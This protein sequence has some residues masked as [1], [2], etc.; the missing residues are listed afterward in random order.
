MSTE[1]GF[2]CDWY[3]DSR[4]LMFE[5]LEQTRAGNPMPLTECDVMWSGT[6]HHNNTRIITCALIQLLCKGNAAQSFCSI[7]Q[8][9]T[10]RRAAVT[11]CV[12]FPHRKLHGTFGPKLYELYMAE[13][14]C[15]TAFTAQTCQRTGF[16]R[17]AHANPIQ[18]QPYARATQ[19]RICLR[20]VTCFYSVIIQNICGSHKWR[21]GQ[22]GIRVSWLSSVS[23]RKGS[24]GALVEGEKKPLLC[25][26]VGLARWTSLLSTTPDPSSL[27]AQMVPC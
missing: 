14:R 25:Q 23:D 5:W 1:C 2:L 3:R 4:K 16:W 21:P 6:S 22:D 26:R 10:H 9:V 12:L 15:R 11:I 8:T 17:W 19:S 7:V 27:P 24:R 18:T 13:T 20:S